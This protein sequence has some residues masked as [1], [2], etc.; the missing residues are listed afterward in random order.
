MTI[1]D[2]HYFAGTVKSIE[3]LGGYVFIDVD[4]QAAHCRAAHFA[5]PEAEAGAWPGQIG[6][7]VVVRLSLWTREE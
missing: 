6:A 3:R 7:P 4:M 5:I 2:P 1:P